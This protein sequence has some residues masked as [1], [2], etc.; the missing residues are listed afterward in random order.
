MMRRI[1][2]WCLVLSHA[3]V[4][5]AS[6]CE[7]TLPPHGPVDS[8]PDPSRVAAARALMVRRDV[9]GAPSA[10]GLRCVINFGMSSAR[11]QGTGISQLLKQGW[12]SKKAPG[13]VFTDVAKSGR[14]VRFWNERTD[15]Q[16]VDAKHKL[17]NNGCTP[18]QVVLGLGMVTQEQPAKLGPMTAGDVAGVVDA[19]HFHFRFAALALGGHPFTGYLDPAYATKVPEPFTYQDSVVLRDELA[20]PQ[21]YPV[22]FRDTWTRGPEV[23]PYTGL[24][25]FCH[26]VEPADGHHPAS[27]GALP[28]AAYPMGKGLLKLA[29]WQIRWW[30][31]VFTY[32]VATDVGL[33]K[34]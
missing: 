29:T 19:F 14:T 22:I 3:T 16:W 12:K 5:S 8:T 20:L 11:R 10:T 2:A 26:D 30:Q 18:E 27:P 6:V 15:P 21:D 31:A 34:P 33:V 4:A 7:V 24:D 25:W 32:D 23:N 28:D 1:V 17:L 13:L 9:F